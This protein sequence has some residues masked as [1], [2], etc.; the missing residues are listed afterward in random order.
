[1]AVEDF[2]SPFGYSGFSDPD[3]ND[4]P[5]ADE[6]AIVLADDIDP[7]T[8]EFLS[9]DGVH[10]VDAHVRYQFQ[11]E[12]GTGAALGRAG[13]RLREIQY[14]DDSTAD[15]L[16]F[17]IKRIFT[18]LGPDWAVLKAANSEAKAVRVEADPTTQYAA[19]VA[20][21]ENVLAQRSDEVRRNLEG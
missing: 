19:V 17:E 14:I 5:P 3:A 8:G 6:P 9:F 12:A 13:N 2:I 4:L 21:Y 20:D 7:N 11:V 16:R 1:M 10:P 15:G 18:Q